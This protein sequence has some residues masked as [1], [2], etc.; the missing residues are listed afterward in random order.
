ML[1]PTFRNHIKNMV[2]GVSEG[3]SKALDIQGVG[4]RANLQGQE[5]V[6]QLGYSHDIRYAVPQEI[7]VAVD[8]QP[9]LPS[10]G[11]TSRKL[12]RLPLKLSLSVRQSPIKAREFVMKASISVKKK[13]RRNNAKA[14]SRS[15]PGHTN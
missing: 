9:R 7:K 8:K 1:W 4:F 6:L 14:L 10:A 12:A 5:L 3:Y 15:V 2:I 13:V 11:S